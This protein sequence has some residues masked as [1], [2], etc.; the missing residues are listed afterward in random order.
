MSDPKL[1]LARLENVKPHGSKTSARC[2]ACAEEG[3]DKTGDNL[4]IFSDGKFACIKYQG[5]DGDAHRQRI[6]AIAGTGAT[7]ATQSKPDDSKLKPAAPT[8]PACQDAAAVFAGLANKAGELVAR[9]EYRDAAGQ[10]VF[11][12]A[13]FEGADGK[14]YRPAR[15]DADGWR[16]ALPVGPL[17]LY[18]LP[19]LL[20]TDPAAT[21]YVCEGEKCADAVRALGAVAT[22]S[23][24]GAGASGKTDWTAL[25]GR[26]VTILPDNDE[27]GRKYAAAVAAIL[28]ALNPP[29]AVK[30]AAL[31]G[32]AELGEGADVFNWLEN[33]DAIEPSELLAAIAAAPATDAP[34]EPEP[35]DRVETLADLPDPAPEAQNPAALFRNGWLRRGGGAL[36][37]APS[38][39]GKSVFS[40]QAAACWAMGQAAFGLA[41]VHPLR[42]CI[43]QAEDDTE[44]MAFFRNQ[45]GEGLTTESGIDAGAVQAAFGKIALLEIIG[46]TG[47]AFVDRLGAHLQKHETDLLIVNPLQ[48]YFGGDLS[49]NSELSAFLRG[50]VDPLIK[51]PDGRGRVGVLFVHHTNKPPTAKERGGW[52]TDAFSA[53][54]GAGGA[55]LVNWARAVLA[56]MPCEDSPGVFRL[57]A[58]KRG[59]RL[60]WVDAAGA[61]TNTRLIAH[62]TRLV[63]WRDATEGETGASERGGRGNR[64]GD[65][66]TDAGTLADTARKAAQGLT[67]LRAYAV[68]LYGSG[69]GRRAFDY[70]IG[71]TAGFK[72]AV[73]KATGKGAAFIGTEPDASAAARAWDTSKGGK[74]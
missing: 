60:G 26:K 49:R 58:G 15:R 42:V 4:A 33:R 68:E 17:P 46:A 2:P 74:L 13:R 54:C 45:I 64:G 70:L 28:Q 43:V 24:G 7:R 50:A 38:G 32:L 6:F 56:L 48:S 14:T 41:P 27:P 18:G 73:I 71:N 29:A 16:A 62:H 44:E 39:V 3:G 11:E 9:W 37:V 19:E 23:Q 8:G 5:P 34:T 21:V 20:T 66:A 63:F 25:A 31:P 72:L 59:Q 65:P 36:L 40:V 22:C 30:I 35:G 69:R 53:Y 51:G 10:V 61:K 55:E 67:S 12:V 52:G 57:V 47:A 1:D